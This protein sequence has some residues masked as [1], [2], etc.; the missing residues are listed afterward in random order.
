MAR[1][2]SAYLKVAYRR[3]TKKQKGLHDKS[4]IPATLLPTIF[5]LFFSHACGLIF[6]WQLG[7]TIGLTSITLY[8]AF[9]CK[10]YR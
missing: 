9:L 5:A 8:I 10:L 4:D 7:L 6:G 2:I 1:Y 3:V